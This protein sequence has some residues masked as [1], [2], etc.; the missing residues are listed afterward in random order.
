M[1]TGLWEMG[2][3]IGGEGPSEQVAGP[4]LPNL[5]PAQEK[6]ELWAVCGLSR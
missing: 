4:A 3:L 6:I 2:W 1:R 5:L